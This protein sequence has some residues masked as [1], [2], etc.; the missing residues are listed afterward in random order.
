M[1]KKRCGGWGRGSP[2]KGGGKK[3]EGGDGVSSHKKKEKK[4]FKMAKP[5]KWATHFVHI[6][7]SRKHIRC[8]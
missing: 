7:T 4:N 3:K 6:H 2:C 1:K 8:M 5:T